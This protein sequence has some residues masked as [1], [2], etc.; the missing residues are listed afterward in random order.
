VGRSSPVFEGRRLAINADADGLSLFS[1]SNESAMDAASPRLSAK[2]EYN[3][4]LGYSAES[5]PRKPDADKVSPR[6]QLASLSAARGSRILWLV[7]LRLL[8]VDDN[9]E[10][11]DS[12][13]RLLESEGLEVVGKASSGSEAVRL[14][15]ALNPDVVLLDVLLGEED[16]FEVARHLAVAAPAVLVVLISTHSEDDLAEGLAEAAAAGFLPKR[17]VSA[18]AIRRLLANV[19]RGT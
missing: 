8:I 1:R 5:T 3:P 14:V 19:N 4:T 9:H 7:P 11:L 6:G 15:A 10:F 18:A 2:S 13:G 17:A 12:A 16:G